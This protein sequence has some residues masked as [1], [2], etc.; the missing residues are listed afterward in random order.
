MTISLTSKLRAQT[1]RTCS[2]FERRGVT[3]GEREIHEGAIGAANEGEGHDHELRG[4]LNVPRL[5]TV[6]PWHRQRVDGLS[7]CG[8]RGQGLTQAEPR[9]GFRIRA[10]Q[11]RLR[12]SDFKVVTKD[13]FTEGPLETFDHSEA[14]SGERSWRS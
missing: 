6:A 3:I 2:D 12:V 10:K 8:G 7:M 5:N 13:V 11:Y 9:I 4:F 1:A 14:S